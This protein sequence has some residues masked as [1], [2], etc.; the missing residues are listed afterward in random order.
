MSERSLVDG[1]NLS[2]IKKSASKAL[3]RINRRLAQKGVV[4]K[5]DAIKSFNRKTFG[6]FG[7]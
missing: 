1:V 3:K 5:Q 6:R 2:R 7:D 4:I